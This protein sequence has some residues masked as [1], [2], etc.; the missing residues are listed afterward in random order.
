MPGTTA[1]YL[2]V[3]LLLSDTL[4]FLVKWL[5][6]SLYP[7]FFMDKLS[8]SRQP[9]LDLDSRTSLFSFN[10]PLHTIAMILVISASHL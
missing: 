7:R 9:E 2:Q 3:R 10:C 4:H 5:T 6:N 1:P 8:R